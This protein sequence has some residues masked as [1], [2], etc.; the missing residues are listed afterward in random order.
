MK[1]YLDVDEEEFD[2][3]YMKITQ[4]VK[5]HRKLKKITQEQL[6]LSIGHTSASMISKI[7]AGLEGKHYNIK[8]LYLISKVLKIPMNHFFEDII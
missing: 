5:K 7:E 3:L 2:K 4:N 1:I 6:A 8:Q